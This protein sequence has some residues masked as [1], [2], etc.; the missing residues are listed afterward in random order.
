MSQTAREF[1]RTSRRRRQIVL[2]R[3]TL[4]GRHLILGVVSILACS[5]PAVA[6]GESTI[7]PSARASEYG[8]EAAPMTGAAAR[9]AVDPDPVVPDDAATQPTA[10]KRLGPP[11]AAPDWRGAARDAGYFVGYQFV[12]LAVLYAAPESISGWSDED[13]QNSFKKWRDN[14]SNPVW[15]SDTWW[16]NYVLHPYWG[17]AYYIRARERGLDRWQSFWYSALLSTLWEYGAEALA[18]PV[19]IQDMVVTPVLGSLVGEYLFAPWRAYI[20]AKAGPL[21]WSDKAVLAL[22]DPL[23]A[24]NAQLDRWLGVKTTLQLHPIGPRLRAPGQR[25]SAFG[26]PAAAQTGTTGW[27]LQV[28]MVW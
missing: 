13:K 3:T 20:R 7:D 21:D 19:S 17:G 16:V 11:A 23:G 18:E 10:Y 5:L 27:R 8:G 22:T 28:H 12:A 2:R 26:S 9:P 6:C 25:P 24:I 1:A 14:V 4:L 15:D